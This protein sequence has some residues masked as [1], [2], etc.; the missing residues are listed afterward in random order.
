MHGAST[1]DSGVRDATTVEE[2]R[3]HRTHNGLIFPIYSHRLNYPVQTELFRLRA[4]S[5]GSQVPSPTHISKSQLLSLKK[6]LKSSCLSL[7]SDLR[8]YMQ[9]INRGIC[10][11]C[12]KLDP[13]LNT[14]VKPH[15]QKVLSCRHPRPTW[16][17]RLETPC[18]VVSPNFSAL[19]GRDCTD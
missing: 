5:H 19:N 7:K 12:K 3:R 17:L 9:K 13:T 8:F 2:V 11:E 6:P 1:Q 16:D 15:L 4:G 14:S 18:E 10:I